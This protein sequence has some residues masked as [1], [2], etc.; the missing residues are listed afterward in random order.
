MSRTAELAAAAL[1]AAAAPREIAVRARG[2][3]K[4]FERG[5]IVALDRADLTIHAGEAIAIAG[6][7][8]CGK[9]TLLNLIAAL[10]RPDAGEIEVF[11]T[12]LRSLTR[13]QADLFRS[14]T[15]G[16]VFQ[17]HNL[18][19]HLTAHENVQIP[20]VR[21]GIS[22]EQRVSRASMLLDRVE[23]SHRVNNLPPTLSGGE[24]QRVA[25]ARALANHPRLIL[26]DEPTGSLD[27]RS[28]SQVLDLMRQIQ[29]EDGVTLVI[30]THDLQ[31]A[32]SASRVVHMRDG[33]ITDA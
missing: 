22:A 29:R 20:M 17:L 33:R 16:F 8:G 28:G 18:L 9:S 3:V 10:D 7:S 31:V 11:G 26:A 6:P 1:E 25:V 2:L 13:K 5:S 30:V 19:P 14:G 27:T 23:M 24:R 21:A 12:S 4:S 32:Q 15:I